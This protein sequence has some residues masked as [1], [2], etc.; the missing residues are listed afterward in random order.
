M[1]VQNANFMCMIIQKA[2]TLQTLR[3]I[4]GGARIHNLAQV[5]STT[6]N[7]LV[8]LASR[9]QHI[10]TESMVLQA[11]HTQGGKMRGDFGHSNGLLGG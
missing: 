9:R 5:Q 8:Y 6:K 2:N 7:R 4:V 3:N 1:T 10:P 11:T